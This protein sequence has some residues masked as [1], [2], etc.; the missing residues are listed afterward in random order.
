MKKIPIDTLP[1]PTEHNVQAAFFQHISMEFMH[2]K[3]F[4]PE[5][6][7][8]VPNGMWAG[9]SSKGGKFGLIAKF[10][11]EGVKPGVADILYLQPRGIHP[12]LAFEFKRE[13]FREAKD[14]GLKPKQ[15]AFKDAAFRVGAFYRVI[16]TVDE[17]VEEFRRYMEYPTR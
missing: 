14:G 7:F 10:I 16:Y 1:Y 12:Y 11:S 6:F 4:I 3:T 5:L 13:N 8:A 2:D 17:G 15:V 9:G